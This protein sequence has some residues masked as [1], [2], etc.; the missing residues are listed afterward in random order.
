[1]ALTAANLSDGAM[2][3]SVVLFSVLIYELVGPT[4]TKWSLT[5]A[6]E[7]KPEGRKSSREINQPDSKPAVTLK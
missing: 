3:R 2:V 6:G 5:Q 4:L 1:M 7:I